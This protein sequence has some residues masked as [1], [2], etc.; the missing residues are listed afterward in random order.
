MPIATSIS[1]APRTKKAPA[2]QPFQMSICE[3]VV[4]FVGSSLW[5]GQLSAVEAMPMATNIRTAPRTKQHQDS[6]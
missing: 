3:H 6:L 4:N 1:T 5:P 2:F